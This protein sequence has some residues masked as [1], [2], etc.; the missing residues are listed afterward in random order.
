[1]SNVKAI[2]VNMAVSDL[3]RSKRFYEALGFHFHEKFTNDE[4]AGLVIS[5]A[6]Y[7]ML[8]TPA[9]LKRFTSKELADTKR[10]S[11]VLLALGVE[12]RA[13]VDD[14]ADRALGAGGREHRDP[15]DHGFMYD[16]AFEDPDGH[17]WEVF[18]MDTSQL[19]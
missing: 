13:Q 15:A 2:Y 16:R 19:P 12:S 10:T 8:H 5:D 17:I 6:I 4:A 1:V 9:S 7:A 11:E 14:L 18:Y 3:E